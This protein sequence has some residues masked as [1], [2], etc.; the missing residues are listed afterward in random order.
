[1]MSAARQDRTESIEIAAA[2]GL[3]LAGRL[4]LPTGERRGSAL[5]AHCFTCSKDLK[6]VVRIS[7]AL[8]ARGWAVLRF[9]FTGLGESDGVFAQTDF[10]S[11]VEDVISAASL[12]SH[13]FG[14]ADLLVGH[15]LG[16]AAVLAA[17]GRIPAVRAV[18]TI[19][20]PS[21]TKHLRDDL[22]RRA[23]ELASGEEAAEIELGG[24]RF[25]IRRQLLD[26]LAE[27]RMRRA[28]EGLDAAL[29]LLH[30]P[31]DE[32]VAID[33]A[34]RL[35][36]MARH[37]KSFVSLDG[38]DHLLL[39][40]PADS[41][42]VAELLAT[43]S[44]R[45]LSDAPNAGEED[46]A[47]PPGVVRAS[48]GRAGYRVRLRAGAHEIVA[49][50]PEE[51]GGRDEGPNPY[52]LLLAALGACK[53]ITMRMYADRKGWPLEGAVLDLTHGRIHVEDCADCETAKGQI[54]EIRVQL[55]LLGDLSAEQRARLTEIAERCPV[56][57]TL[58]TETRIRTRVPSDDTGSST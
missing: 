3:T 8:A 24:R 23:P 50:E 56:H 52:D 13:R 18:A 44:S 6:A 25:T 54:D 32:V 14:A 46:G 53:G 36:E 35:Y 31:V 43:W 38:A 12:L 16:G 21:D 47:G 49:D 2:S 1:M 48:V 17:A 29:L 10:T 19:G 34:R 9:D 27:E 51:A 41:Q 37:P 57:R 28:L 11:N 20:A 7:R 30:S 5:F 39:E 42:F 58:S 33:H 15:S 55:E 4:E 22:L 26:D 40:R 45:Y